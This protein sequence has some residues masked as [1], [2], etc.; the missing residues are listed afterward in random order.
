MGRKKLGSSIQEGRGSTYPALLSSISSAC[1]LASMAT[2]ENSGLLIVLSNWGW[3]ICA[4]DFGNDTTIGRP[5]VKVKD[6][7][8]SPWVLIRRI[9]F[10]HVGGRRVVNGAAALQGM[11]CT[12]GL[13]GKVDKGKSRHRMDTGRYL[14]LDFPP[15]FRN[16]SPNS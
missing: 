12:D 1:F 11:E 13:K 6:F 9:A 5:I 14:T 7:V 3:R 2:P 4:C 8:P 16:R 10:L 15:T